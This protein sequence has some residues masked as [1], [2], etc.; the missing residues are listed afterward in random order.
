[1]PRFF[2]LAPSNGL[3]F[4]VFLGLACLATRAAWTPGHVVG[5]GVDLYGTLWFYWW[6]LECL[7]DLRDPG[8]TDLIFYPLGKDIFAHTGNNLLDATASIP[9]QLMF[10]P[11]EYQKWFVLALLV[12]N[13][14]AF[15]PL[16]REVLGKTWGAF[17]A[18]VAWM[19]NPYTLFEIHC[20][21][22]TQ[23]FLV[24]TPLAFLAMLRIQRG[25]HWRWG[26]LL[27]LSVALQAWTYWFMG[28]F[29]AIGLLPLAIYGWSQVK[30]TRN[31][32]RQLFLAAG[33]C[34]LLVAP[35]VLAMVAAASSGG[36]PGLATESAGVLGSPGQLPNN[37]A[38]GLHGYDLLEQDNISILFTISWGLPLLYWLFR[39]T[40]RRPWAAVLVTVLA[41]SVG[42][43]LELGGMELVMPH[44]MLLYDH[45]PFFDRR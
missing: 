16:A 12:A 31:Y 27:G 18:S 21:R 44:Y 17:G 9:F 45:L 40:S 41:F 11:M 25:R 7:A 28:W 43:K 35:A 10:G 34:L 22:L 23:A 1:M 39:G 33:C 8:F 20:G 37:V 24:F 13:G 29:M 4:T 30:D 32:A 6:Q 26:I 15:L 14:L 2:R 5:A 36:V 42:P 3:A 19:I 38:A